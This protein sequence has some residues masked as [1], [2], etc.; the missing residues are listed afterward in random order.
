ME[1]I[2]VCCHSLQIYSIG[3]VQAN[4]NQNIHTHTKTTATTTI[5]EIYSNRVFNQC[6]RF[7]NISICSAILS[8]YLWKF[9]QHFF[10]LC[11][12][13]ECVC[14]S[15]ASSCERF[16]QPPYAIHYTLNNI[17]FIVSYVYVFRVFFV[18]VVKAVLLSLVL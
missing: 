12:R 14:M 10:M 3:I 7:I 5:I 4:R 9:E 16:S 15:V 2:K 8:R 18:R 1:R 11:A 17:D 13:C 6:F